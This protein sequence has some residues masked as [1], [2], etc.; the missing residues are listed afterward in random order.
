MTDIELLKD[1]VDTLKGLKV[2]VDEIETVGIP[3]YRVSSNLQA[4]LEQIIKNAKAEEEK[5]QK[6]EAE[7]EP[8]IEIEPEN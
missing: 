5:K 7:P 3:V 6:S 2:G 1:A 4:L 8:A